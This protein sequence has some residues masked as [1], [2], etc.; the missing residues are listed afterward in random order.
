VLRIAPHRYQSARGAL[1]ELGE[2]LEPLGERAL[3]IAN[4]TALERFEDLV[5]SSLKDS[6]MGVS[7]EVCL[8]E[9][10]LPEVERL[11]EV[12]DK[13]DADMIVGIG[14]GKTLDVAKY[15]AQKTG[16]RT[17]TIPSV[18]SSYAAFSNQVYLFNEDGKFIEVKELEVCPDLLIMDYK[19]VGLAAPRYLR[20]GM[21]TALAT[22]YQF[23]LSQEELEGHHP[24]RLAFELAAHLRE[25][26]FERGGKAL[27]DVRREEVTG[28]V[29]TILETNLLQAGLVSSLGG[30]S[31]RSMVAHHLAHEI[32][33]YVQRDL[34]FGELVAFGLLVE[35]ML[36]GA[37]PDSLVDLLEFFREV[38]LPLTLDE[39]DLPGNQRGSILE[40]A[41]ETITEKLSGWS[42][43]FEFHPGALLE[44]V[45]QTDETGQK[46]R[47]SG[48]DS[49][50]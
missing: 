38:D 3:V 45:S 35:H 39:L 13:E 49:L 16:R 2:H 17:V 11:G 14:A 20:A 26:L 19:V 30:V 43:P 7:F 36:Y 44:A 42:F 10:C 33:P 34:L 50:G 32:Q 9:C 47:Q 5:R 1:Q 24:S 6:M 40:D 27:Q 8:G 4:K 46:V 29:E 28:R 21:G 15:T 23:T 41:A 25:Q 18:A 12:A 22:S 37:R 48:V 31:F